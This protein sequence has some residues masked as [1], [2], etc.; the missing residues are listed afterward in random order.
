LSS[1]ANVN[2]I[3]SSRKWEKNRDLKM[4][5]QTA[6]NDEA[7]KAG[8][9]LSQDTPA[10]REYLVR[11]G[12]KD[13]L[14]A[15]EQ[16]PNS[17]GWYDKKT[18]Q[19]LAVAALVH[20]ELKGDPLKQFA[21]T[22]IL[23]VTSNG[24][25]V[26]KNFEL[27]NSIYIQYKATGKMPENMGEG[28]ALEAMNNSLKLFNTLAETWGMENFRK[29]MMTDYTVAEITSID[30]NLT[31]GGENADTIVRGAAII[32]P[33][34][35][36]G[37]FSNLNGVFD[38]LTMDRWLM[39]TWGR[40]TGTLIQEDMPS[41]NPVFRLRESISSLS[42]EQKKT[43]SEMIG[44]DISFLTPNQVAERLAPEMALKANR[45]IL[46]KDPV[47]LELRLSANSMAKYLDGQKEAPKSGTE[48]NLIRSIRYSPKSK[49]ILDMRT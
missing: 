8:I 2:K 28:T 42:E 18:R 10:V 21:Y 26:N 14:A 29:F 49:A 37:F 23:A 20:P 35:G 34:I 33:K 5:M 19:A 15:L 44:T 27:C 45:Q 12:V 13:A 30:P 16:N 17:V 3:S 4:A 41:L 38:A 48:R 46:D 24:M 32:G 43:V 11:V 47:T 7:K 1:L 31:P 6:L 40:W 9:D 25:K 39:R 36:N 22:Y